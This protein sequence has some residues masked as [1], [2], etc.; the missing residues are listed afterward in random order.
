MYLV[1]Y[2]YYSLWTVFFTTSCSIAM[3][4]Y[5][6]CLKTYLENFAPQKNE[7]SNGVVH[8][9][10]D[11]SPGAALLPADQ[12]AKQ[13]ASLGDVPGANKRPEEGNA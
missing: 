11:Y 10:P 8:P 9:L 4:I 13:D 7:A 1:Y 12:L 2:A 6:I 3:L 5:T